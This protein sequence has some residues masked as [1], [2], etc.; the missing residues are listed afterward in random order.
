[1]V[2]VWRGLLF[3][4]V[5][6][7]GYVI[8]LWHSPSLPYNY[9]GKK[10]NST[11]CFLRRNLHHTPQSCRKNAYLALVRSKMEYGSVIWDPYTKQDIQKLEN[12]Q[13]SSAR[14]IMKD[15]HSRQEGCVTEMLNEL[16][17]PTLQDRCR[18]QRLSL[19]YKVVERHVP[20]INPDHYI[21]PQRQRRA[22]RATR[23]TDYEHKNIVE[24]YSTNNSKC[25]KR[26]PAKTE[27][28][29]LR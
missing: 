20:A 7:M 14:F 6:G 15:C 29:I 19:M 22:I 3:L 24:N 12:V 23:F 11:L 27:K 21:Q 2:S 28:L 4:W 9:L 18:D 8:L 17:L 16:K 1:M 25:F 5:L 26:I 13:R 10:T